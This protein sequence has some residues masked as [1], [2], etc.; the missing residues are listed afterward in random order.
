MPIVVS[1]VMYSSN[2]SAIAAIGYDGYTLSVEFHSGKIYDHPG[3]PLFRLRRPDAGRFQRRI[4]Q[5]LHS[6]EVSVSP[7]GSN[8]ADTQKLLRD[9]AAEARELQSAAG[10][11]VTDAVAG[12]LAVAI[13][14]GGA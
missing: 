14:L 8:L 5:P 2:S 12:W 11:S 13:C 1:M 10:G 4:L 7:P 9:M 6:R 3:V